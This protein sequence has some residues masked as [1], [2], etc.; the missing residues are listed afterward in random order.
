LLHRRVS[1]RTVA[2]RSLNNARSRVHRV[3]RQLGWRQANREQR[4]LRRTPLSVNLGTTRLGR[5]CWSRAVHET[6]LAANVFRD[7]FGLSRSWPRFAVSLVVRHEN[8]VRIWS[9]LP[10]T[11]GCHTVQSSPE[12]RRDPSVPS[13]PVTD[14][15]R[16][17]QVRLT[18]PE[19][20]RLGLTIDFLKFTP[21]APRTYESR[22][23]HHS[24]DMP[25]SFSYSILVKTG[26]G[27][28]GRAMEIQSPT[29]GDDWTIDTSDTSSGSGTSQGALLST[30]VRGS[31]VRLL[32]D[33]HGQDKLF[34]ESP[35]KPEI[36]VL[37]V[38]A[39]V[40]GSDRP[41]TFFDTQDCGWDDPI[42]DQ[43]DQRPEAPAQAPTAVAPAQPPTV[44]APS[45]RPP[46]P[47]V[48][49]PPP[50]PDADGHG[51][52]DYPEARCLD[53][54]P[55]VALGRTADSL[56]LICQVRQGEWYYKGYGLKNQLP[57]FINGAQRT[58]DGFRATNNGFQYQ[59]APDALTIIQGAAR[60]SREPMLE[61]WLSP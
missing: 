7:G 8:T 37:L 56:V 53:L 60:V 34:T 2:A 48:A 1:A 27:D 18:H 58:P 49:A 4:A 46:P 14:A 22:I 59:V 15:L 25:G 31:V 57:L 36:S 45:Q 35:F 33:Q 38:R 21:R 11:M 23:T 43:M 5:H 44:P 50:L 40:A 42:A 16:M 9:A 26:R 54:D 52:V 30:D 20:E 17:R 51:F 32:L 55:A 28:G 10:H 47:I 29:R 19:G 6:Y 3:A 12:E 13:L 41:A 61:Y 24:E 39:G